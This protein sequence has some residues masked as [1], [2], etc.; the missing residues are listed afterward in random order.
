MH[1]TCK[2]YLSFTWKALSV[3]VGIIGMPVDA[4]HFTTWWSLVL[5]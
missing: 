3:V 2:F 4:L 5:L 1:S